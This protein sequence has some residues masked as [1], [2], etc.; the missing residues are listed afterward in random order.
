MR[1]E[2]ERSRWRLLLNDPHIAPLTAY[3]VG[4]WHPGVEVPDFDPFDGG[5]D[6]RAL[7]LLEKPGPL[8]AASRPDVRRTGSGFISRDN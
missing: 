7:F 5:V 6:A 3:A 8:T 4:L 1:D 2:A